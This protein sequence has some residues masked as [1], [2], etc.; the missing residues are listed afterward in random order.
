MQHVSFAGALLRSPRHV[1]SV[2]P[3]SRRLG[4]RLATVV[5]TTD[6]AVIVE[7]GAGT[8]AVTT[9]IEHRRSPGSTFLAFERDPQLAA[10]L[11]RRSPSV[12]VVS[13]DARN[14]R[15]T[16]ARFR[17]GPVDAVVSGL[18]W[19]NFSDADQRALLDEI[20]LGLAP[21]GSFTTFAYVHAL[22]MGPA[23]RFR[24]LLS[25]HFE[26]VAKT[27]AILW[28]IPPAITYVCRRPRLADAA[29]GREDAGP[30]AV[31]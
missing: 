9:S 14:L 31:A 20:C 23:R 13:D 21:D 22:R 29:P 4:D 6:G 8:G 2:A 28:N 24:A 26:D 12:H 11:T 30:A 27:P 10:R 3:S 15:A 25:E 7:L 17:L 1:G 18:P 5:P 16:L 19:A